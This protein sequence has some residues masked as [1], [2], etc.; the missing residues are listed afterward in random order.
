MLDN[1][2]A[3]FLTWMADSSADIYNVFL[4]AV[5]NSNNDCSTMVDFPIPG[6]PHSKFTLPYTQPPPIHDPILQTPMPIDGYRAPLHQ[7]F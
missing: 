7:Q 4:L 2:F 3:R 6:S 1:R 5:F